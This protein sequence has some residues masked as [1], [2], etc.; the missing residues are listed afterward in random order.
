MMGK[1]VDDDWGA[2]AS[3]KRAQHRL[4]LKG[5]MIALAVGYLIVA[6]CASP[7]DG[8]LHVMSLALLMIVAMLGGWAWRQADEIQRRISIN[9][10]AVVGVVSLMLIPVAHIGAAMIG[11]PDPTLSVFLFAI[12]SGAVSAV[13]QRIRG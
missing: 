13:F 8:V 6:L 2:R 4:L 10:F 12:I 11:R 1:I 7:D 5:V 3:A 9:A